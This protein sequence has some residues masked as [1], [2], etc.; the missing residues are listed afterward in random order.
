MRRRVTEAEHDTPS[1]AKSSG[2]SCRGA[3]GTSSNGQG[4]THIAC[5]AARCWG[6]FWGLQRSPEAWAKR[7]LWAITFPEAYQILLPTPPKQS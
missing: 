2:T 7:E 1:V 6:G 3:R 4:R 5:T